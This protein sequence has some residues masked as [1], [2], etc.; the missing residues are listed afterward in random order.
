[1]S[2]NPERGFIIFILITLFIG[3]ASVF[4]GVAGHGDR[5]GMHIGLGVIML[6]FG[7]FLFYKFVKRSNDSGQL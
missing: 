4:E 6:A 1:M 3:M 2:K 7:G 5:Q